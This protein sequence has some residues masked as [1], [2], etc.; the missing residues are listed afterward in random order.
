MKNAKEAEIVETKPA[1]TALAAA[2]AGSLRASLDPEMARLMELALEKGAVDSLERLVALAE[3]TDAK[4]AEREL[5]LAIAAFKAECPPIRRTKENKGVSR[6]GTSQGS[7]YAP[8]D[9]IARTIDP[10]LQKHGLSY[11]WDSEEIESGRR[12]TCT[13][14]HIG[15]ASKESKFTTVIPAGTRANNEAQRVGIAHAYGWRYT[16]VGVLGLT[17]CD[18]DTDGQGLK[19][20]DSDAITADQAIVLSDLLTETKSDR[21]K[22]LAIYG[23][24]SVED[25][26]ASCYAPAKRM[27]EAKKG[28]S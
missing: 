13:L 19:G 22:F 4:R 3:R 14:S 6:E 28:K 27:L 9:E 5:I 25:L 7:M 16:L 10:I 2:Q 12:I 11:T 1:G 15:G 23:V 21:V 18:K 20:D 24:Q 17:S 8:L 26:P